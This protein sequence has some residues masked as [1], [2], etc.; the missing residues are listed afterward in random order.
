MVRASYQIGRL[1]GVL[2]VAVLGAAI[3]AAMHFVLGYSLGADAA[4]IFPRQRSLGM[5]LYQSIWGRIAAVDHLHH[6]GQLP[7]DT[8]LGVFI[9]VSTTATGIRRQYLDA[10]ANMA[11]RWIVLAGAGLSFENIESVMLPVFFCDLKPSTVVFGVHPQMLVGEHYLGDEP[12]V[13]PENVV[14]RRRRMMKSQFKWFGASDWLR[15]HWAIRHRALMADF[16]RSW[17]Y[18]TRVMVFYRAGVS[19]EW[20]A[21]PSSQPW[22]EDPLWLWNMD[23]AENL[24]AE[25]QIKFWERRGHFEAES[26]HADGDQAHSFVRMIRAYRRLGAKVYIVIM[27]LRSSVRA[28][29]P[30]NAKP[31]LL[32]VLDR[33]FPESPPTIFD[34][35]S[36]MPDRFF[37]DE[38]HLSLS[39][40]ERLSKQVAELLREPAPAEAPRGGP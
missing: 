37:T 11:D 16:L 25:N 13:G 1:R 21:P 36:A 7:R 15:K 40:G 26:Y 14:G 20:L 9:G 24:F 17:F 39:G 34:L 35:E 18:A 31:C 27:P 29:V 12:A 22:D 2:V 30:P 32:E 3:F 4:A 8:R 19:A 38:A 28:I 5:R 6:T 33:E 23:D 10:R